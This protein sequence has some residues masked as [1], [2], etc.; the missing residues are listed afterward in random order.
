MSSRTLLFSLVAVVL[1]RSA[2]AAPPT[3][4][5]T[6]TPDPAYSTLADAVD[7]PTWDVSSPTSPPWAWTRQTGRVGVSVAASPFLNFGERSNLRLVISGPGRLSF[8]SMILWG[9]QLSM[10]LEVDVDGV[11]TAS[12]YGY[13]SNPYANG[14]HELWLASGTHVVLWSVTLVSGWAYSDDVLQLD[15]FA[16]MAGTPSPTVTCSP[17]RTKS[18]TSTATPTRTVTPTSTVTPTVTQTATISPT[19]TP[20]ELG[21]AV[22]QPAWTFTSGGERNI[23]AVSSLSSTA[24]SSAA[25]MPLSGTWSS[26]WMATDVHG[27]AD[28]RYDLSFH[29]VVNLEMGVSVDGV[30]QWHRYY[31][32][33]PWTEWRTQR[34][35]IP[36]GTHRVAWHMEYASSGSGGYICVDNLVWVP[37]AAPENGGKVYSYPNPLVM[38][39]VNRIKFKFPPCVD[40]Q[41]DIFDMGGHKLINLKG[42]PWVVGSEGYG[43]WDGHLSGGD[44]ASPGIYVYVLRCDVSAQHGK[45]TVVRP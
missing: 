30:D 6:R 28:L 33:P 35:F 20:N 15:N 40:A 44:W 36:G 11:R 37:D 18:P 23:F 9:G 19:F 14:A 4:T 10:V 32:V 12:N 17:T 42:S 27:P 3:P 16:F 45:L 31:D 38:D 22:E 13:F 41:I 24:G 8:D 25:C 21:P 29:N 1:L 7:Q 34:L 26:G 39:H 2:Q 43:E 5:I